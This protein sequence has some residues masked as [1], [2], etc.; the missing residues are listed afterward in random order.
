MS[1][2]VSP[3]GQFR[4]FAGPEPLSSIDASQDTLGGR[5]HQYLIPRPVSLARTLQAPQPGGPG[6]EISRDGGPADTFGR[7]GALRWR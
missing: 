4:N 7:K 6:S 5:L 3:V 2:G 1:R